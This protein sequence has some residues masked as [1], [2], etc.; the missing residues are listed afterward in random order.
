MEVQ[1]IF[2]KKDSMKRKDANKWIRDHKYKIGRVDITPTLWR[3]RQVEPN[4]FVQSS[5]R[6]KKL[7]GTKIRDVVG[8]KKRKK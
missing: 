1:S 2:I 5:F 7:D 8:K 3:F 6:M 4:L